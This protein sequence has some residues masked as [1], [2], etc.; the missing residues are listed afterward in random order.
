MGPSASDATNSTQIT[1][2]VDGI[3]HVLAD[4]LLEI[5]DYQR[6]YSWTLDEVAELWRD[7]EKAMKASTQDYFLGSIVTTSGSGR[8]QVIDGQQRLAT[9]SLLF[10]AMRDIFRSRSDERADEIER[11]Y[12]GR[13][14]MSTRQWEPK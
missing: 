8:D 12:L 14:N 11:D 10:A 4:S 1:T 6:S 13:K 5:P 3:A 7:I 2:A 9:V